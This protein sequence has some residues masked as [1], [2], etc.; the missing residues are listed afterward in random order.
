MITEGDK[1]QADQLI[2]NERRQ[3][4]DA[5]YIAALFMLNKTVG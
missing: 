2:Y 4:R 1:T 3:T 5:N